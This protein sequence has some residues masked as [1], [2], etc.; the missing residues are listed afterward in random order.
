[1]GL[2]MLVTSTVFCMRLMQQLVRPYGRL[3]AV[4]TQWIQ[5]HALLIPEVPFTL[6]EILEIANKFC[7]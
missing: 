1:M 2:Y 3:K 5:V 6:P 7:S 4:E